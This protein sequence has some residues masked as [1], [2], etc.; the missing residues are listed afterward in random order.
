MFSTL[1]TVRQFNVGAS[2]VE[3]ASFAASSFT[4]FPNQLPIEGAL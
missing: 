3:T 2:S 1:P 4:R